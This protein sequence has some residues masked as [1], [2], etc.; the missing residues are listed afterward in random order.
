MHP[1]IFAFPPDVA[2]LSPSSR[3]HDS[4]PVLGD[5]V[6][7]VVRIDKSDGAEGRVEFGESRMEVDED[8]AIIHVPLVGFNPVDYFVMKTFRSLNFL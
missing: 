6:W 1:T 8:A 5:I 4:P 7:S 3:S 2:L